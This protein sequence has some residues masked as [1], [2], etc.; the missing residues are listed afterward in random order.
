VHSLVT[1]DEFVGEGQTGHETALLEPEDRGECSTE[2][3]TL[4]SS[5][6]DETRGEGRVV[7]ADPFQG[8]V[9]LLADAWDWSDLLVV[10]VDIPNA[11]YSL[12]SMALKR[13][14]RCLGSLINVSIKSEYVSE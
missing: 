10:L 5:E 11:R 2:E 4:D 1:G 6:C 14:V 3:D 9:C 8:P 12:F 7:I 13:Y